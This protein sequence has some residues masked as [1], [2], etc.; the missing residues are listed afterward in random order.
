VGLCPQ[1]THR[2][3]SPCAGQADARN[4]LWGAMFANVFVRYNMSG[5]VLSTASA[6]LSYRRHGHCHRPATP[7][8]A[9]QT[10]ILGSN[11]RA[12]HALSRSTMASTFV[13]ISMSGTDP[14]SR[15]TLP[16]AEPEDKAQ[17]L[18]R[19][20]S[21]AHF[22][23][24]S[25]A[26]QG[27]GYRNHSS[28]HSVARSSSLCARMTSPHDR[29][30]YMLSCCMQHQVIRYAPSTSVERAPPRAP[31]HPPVE[32]PGVVAVAQ[33]RLRRGPRLED[34]ELTD[35]VRRGLTRKHAVPL[36]LRS[37]ENRTING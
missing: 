37:R 4:R 12:L 11:H 17:R 25:P 22:P 34:L 10:P 6:R 26:T 23:H 29:I 15:S 28:P 3:T 36:H 21:H 14:P 9:D 19:H 1:H 13:R 35:L 30:L 18:E 7:L 20:S 33:R 2:K 8:K 31:Q 16:C 5:V 32:G 24:Q 27:H